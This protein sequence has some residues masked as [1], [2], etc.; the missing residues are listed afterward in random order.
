MDRHSSRS[1]ENYLSL[2]RTIFFQ[3]VCLQSSSKE[4]GPFQS[5]RHTEDPHIMKKVIPFFIEGKGKDS[6]SSWLIKN[7]Y[8]SCDS[9]E[10]LTAVLNQL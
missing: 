4:G 7:F 5:L 9:C 10:W 6:S 8:C 1:H 2:D 3:L